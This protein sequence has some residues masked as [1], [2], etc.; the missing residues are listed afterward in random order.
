MPNGRLGCVNSCELTIDQLIVSWV[1]V[2]CFN[3]ARVL[4][5]TV[6]LLPCR[7][8]YIDMTWPPVTRG[9]LH[10]TTMMSRKHE[11][12]DSQ[13]TA[14]TRCLWSLDT[15]ITPRW[16]RR[17]RRSARSFRGSIQTSFWCHH[18]SRAFVC[19][20]HCLL[21]GIVWLSD[22]CAKARRCLHAE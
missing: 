12:W 13:I 7:L 8:Y 19:H 10:N 18:Y 21:L 4:G 9:F 3:A 17:W 5:E 14:G 2:W 16:H 20:N 1:V 22:C 6:Y 11:E 15:M